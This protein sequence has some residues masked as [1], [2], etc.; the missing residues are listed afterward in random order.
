MG[1]IDHAGLST[2][3]L[4]KLQERFLEDADLR[5]LSHDVYRLYFSFDASCCDS[6]VT[7][8]VLRRRERGSGKWVSALRVRVC[9]P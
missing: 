3:P 5:A 6:L 2:M 1:A 4:S 8:S 7:S 9:P